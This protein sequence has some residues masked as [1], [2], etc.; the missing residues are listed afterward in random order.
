MKT[1]KAGNGRDRIWEE[2]RERREELTGIDHC[3]HSKSPRGAPKA[4]KAPK[5]SK[6]STASASV[7]GSFSLSKDSWHIVV[8]LGSRGM[9][10]L[11]FNHLSLYNID[12]TSHEESLMCQSA[13]EERV[14][15]TRN[16]S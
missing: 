7:Y 2:Q 16:A 12:H 14:D 8:I 15:L 6:T 10:R 1:D 9:A 4:P 11:S 13:I 5:A 3:S